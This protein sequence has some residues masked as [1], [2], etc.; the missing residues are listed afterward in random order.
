MARSLSLSFLVL[1]A[2]FAVF[3]IC[4]ASAD[5]QFDIMAGKGEITVTTKG[6]WHVN[7]EYPWRV[8]V[9]DKTIDKSKFSLTETSA[10]ITGVPPG[11]AKLKGAVCDGPS[12]MP[13]SKDVA[14]P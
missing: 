12:C 11:I 7:K 3:G 9:G 5:E 4:V 2:A 14:V 10:K 6:H 1:A 13:F 8:V